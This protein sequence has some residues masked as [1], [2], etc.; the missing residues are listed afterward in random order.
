MSR[1]NDQPQERPEK[2]RINEEAATWHVRIQNGDVQ[3][4]DPDYLEW[5]AIS[6]AHGAAMRRA[7]ELW[8]LVGDEAAAPEMVKARRDAL[9][10]SGKAAS[11]RW[12]VF[13]RAP[14]YLK[15]A[16]AA[17]M[18]ALVGAPTLMLMSER[19]DRTV[20]AEAPIVDTYQ[21]D[22]AETRIVTLADN[23]RVSLDASTTLTVRYSSEARDIELKEGQAHF[24]V[25][26]DEARPFRVTA[27]DQTIVA[28][29]TAFNIEL[30]GEEVLVTL[31]EGEVIVTD[32]AVLE[33]VVATNP[34]ATAPR[35]PQRPAPVKM[36]PGQLLVASV[37]AA[38]QIVEDTNIEKTNAWRD[39][40]V[41]LEGDSL[42][43]AVAR[44]N[45][46]SRIELT[47]ADEALVD[48]RL[49]GVFNA[50]DTDAFIEAVEAYFPIEAR[51]MSASRIEFH[52]ST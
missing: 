27:G 42:V 20:V 7:R 49:S 16:A 47:V 37:E 12:S 48:L 14:G 5:L 45:R 46:Y 50:G 24:D 23:S 52:S 39:G 40:K 17:A 28:T 34:N 41:F 19:N 31:L 1:K 2:H 4:D 29:G 43:A 22:I 6:P 44:M 8:A 21:T 13:G 9:N 15:V 10:H 32:N 35:T 51:R 18:I 36:K 25:A 26:K 30:V 11:K 33:R 3:M 38:P